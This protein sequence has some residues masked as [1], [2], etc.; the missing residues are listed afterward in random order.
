LN[1]PAA[2]SRRRCPLHILHVGGLSRS[3]LI[4]TANPQLKHKSW[5]LQ[6]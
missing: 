1:F 2:F 3:P 5:Q 6:R 4:I